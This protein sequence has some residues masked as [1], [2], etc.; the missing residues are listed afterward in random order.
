MS[1]GFHFVGD[2]P[3]RRYIDR[4]KNHLPMVLQMEF[5]RQKNIPAWNLL[6]DFY[7]VGDIMI[8]RQL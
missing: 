4:K 3:F 8:Y 5:A 7:S 1:V 6:T 2:S